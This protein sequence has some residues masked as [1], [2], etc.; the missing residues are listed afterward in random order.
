VLYCTNAD[1]DEAH[2]G[3]FV[4]GGGATNPRYCPSCRLK[5]FA[6]MESTHCEG[7]APYREARVQFN[8]DAAELRFRGLALVIDTTCSPD[9]GVFH[10]DTALIRTEKRALVVAESW[11]SKLQRFR[12]STDPG[13]KAP[14]ETVLRIDEPD[15]SSQLH[16]WSLAASDSH[17][18]AS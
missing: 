6:V 2:K 13:S 7:Q 11:L 10:L 9:G 15:F 17:L 8:F 1:C 4:F 3:I 18:S 5:L 12:V 16:L 14:K